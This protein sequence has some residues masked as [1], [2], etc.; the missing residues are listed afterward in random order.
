MNTDNTNNHS[1]TLAVLRAACGHTT[2][3]DIASS[4][5]YSVGKVNYILKALIEKGLI[6]IENFSNSTNKKNY[7][8][9]LTE[10]GIKEKIILTEKFIER[11]KKEYEELQSELEE[12][13]KCN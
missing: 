4:I 13:K 8:Y 3:R 12:M 9:L 1:D 7:K 6:K 11:K 5:G 10:Q 2:Q